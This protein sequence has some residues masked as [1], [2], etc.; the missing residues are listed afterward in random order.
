MSEEEQDNVPK[1]CEAFEAQAW[2]KGICKNC[3]QPPEKHVATANGDVSTFSKHE[4]QE[5]RAVGKGANATSIKDKYEQLERD[6]HLPKSP[7]KTLPRSKGQGTIAAFNENYGSLDRKT[8]RVPESPSGNIPPPVFPKQYKKDGDGS[9]KKSK[10]GSVE[11]VN[12]TDGDS[13]PGIGMK[14]KNRFGS[15]E[16]I[17][18][19]KKEPLHIPIQK[20]KFGGSSENISGKD[21]LVAGSPLKEKESELLNKLDSFQ[22]EFKSGISSKAGPTVI[23]KQKDGNV[24][25]INLPPKDTKKDSG[26]KLKSRFDTKTQ[27]NTSDSKQPG[28]LGLKSKTDIKSPDSST[29]LRSLKDSLSSAKKVVNN[30]N[31]NKSNR[32]PPADGK[33]LLPK[34]KDQLKSSTSDKTQP[35]QKQDKGRFNFKDNLKSAS[36]EKTPSSL[37]DRLKSPPDNEKKGDIPSWKDKLKSN[38]SPVKE[39][40][41]KVKS[42]TPETDKL[43]S[44]SKDKSETS[45]NKLKDRLKSPTLADKDNKTS[46]DRLKSPVAEDNTKPGHSLKDK[47][48]SPTT[49]K[50]KPLENKTETEKPNK[51]FNLKD[52]LKSVKDIS[53]TKVKD[54]DVSPT[55]V[56]D[57]S[58]HDEAKNK[59]FNKDHLLKSNKKQETETSKS[60]GVEE[61]KV[62][63]FKDQLKSTKSERDTKSRFE[64]DNDESS[65]TGKTFDLRG[66]LKKAGDKEKSSS[67]VKQ[68]GKNKFELP[69]LKSNKQET[70]STGSKVKPSNQDSIEAETP[71]VK[72]R[73]EIPKLKS[74]SESVD[75]TK[76]TDSCNQK[77]ENTPSSKVTDAEKRNKDKTSD[78]S[79]NKS[80]TDTF[81]KAKSQ[82]HSAHDN[83]SSVSDFH[84]E[85]KS[86]DENRRSGPV[87][88][89]VSSKDIPPMSDISKNDFENI[90]VDTD[91]VSGD[92]GD[93]CAV[94]TG[95][96]DRSPMHVDTQVFTSS[97]SKTA[98]VN[99]IAE[100]EGLESASG[101]QIGFSGLDKNKTLPKDTDAGVQDGDISQKPGDKAP[102][103]FDNC[104][105]P[106][107]V[108]SAGDIEKLKAE[109]INMTE[110]CQNLEVEN[111]MLS[112]NLKKKE[113]TETTL[114]K[115]KDDIEQ[116][117]K[118]LQCQLKTMEDKCSQLESNNNDVLSSSKTAME[119]NSS[120]IAGKDSDEAEEKLSGKEKLMEDMMEENEQLKQEINELKAEMEEM[121]DSFRDQEAEE[122]RELQKELEYTAKNCRILQFKLRKMERKTEQVEKDKAQYEDRLR[123]LQNQFQDRDAVSHIHSLEDELRVSEQYGFFCIVNNM[124]SCP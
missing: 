62:P 23:H 16:N 56:T 71:E 24:D 36:P 103:T 81:Q 12:A 83:R 87:D 106:S 100:T 7:P 65:K 79:S 63:N 26:G 64:K 88:K 113:S 34:S 67:D 59:G 72:N 50:N 92:K 118:G 40:H 97:R 122:F 20:G 91:D 44:I 33:G 3:F 29:D 30:I 4:G 69:S 85:N 111:E 55:K 86:E 119:K 51:A 116:A 124:L 74:K 31:D 14:G 48:K 39:L 18:D 47:L 117:I 105:K 49:D 41:D 109:L 112:S 104:P 75:K 57:R 38:K 19:K 43:S 25:V 54:K 22:N 21:K 42:P 99:E 70:Q 93:A 60:P 6:K 89:L 77:K 1:V 32:D 10:F 78:T 98:G 53:P 90:S 2:R 107:V 52:Q 82:A 58:G 45:V 68:E 76:V 5:P 66:G 13:T 108:Y 120:N 8:G 102:E 27:D 95:A 110:R 114:R 17:A 84:K 11:N 123:K 73:F 9:L 28:K 15:M 37:K 96:R 101:K 61:K 80:A 115:Q 94:S 121:Y 35:E 46:V